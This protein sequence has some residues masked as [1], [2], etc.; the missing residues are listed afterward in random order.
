M[1]VDPQQFSIAVRIDSSGHS[2]AACRIEGP[3]E[4]PVHVLANQCFLACRK[5]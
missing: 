4:Y 2:Q 5:L 1:L 3:A